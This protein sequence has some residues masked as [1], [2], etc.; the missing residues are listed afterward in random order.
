MST[1]EAERASKGAAAVEGGRRATPSGMGTGKEFRSSIVNFIRV[2]VYFFL[3][4]RD[5][6]PLFVFLNSS[7]TDIVVLARG[8]STS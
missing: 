8:T 4:F 2:R 1:E 5:V 6:I 3:L 7:E